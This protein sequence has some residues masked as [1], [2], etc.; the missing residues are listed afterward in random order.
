MRSGGEA[1]LRPCRSEPEKNRTRQRAKSVTCLPHGLLL[2]LLLS[3]NSSWRLPLLH[4]FTLLLRCVL[5]AEKALPSSF[6]PS[7][8]LVADPRVL[9]LLPL[10]PLS[11]FFFSLYPPPLPCRRCSLLS[12]LLPRH[13]LKPPPLSPLHWILAPFCPSPVSQRRLQAHTLQEQDRLL[14]KTAAKLL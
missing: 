13:L 11:P 10:H 9:F 2:P 1:I 8:L 6:V 5:T 7:L 12:S 14:Q 3:T 4:H